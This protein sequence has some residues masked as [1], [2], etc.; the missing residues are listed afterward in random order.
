MAVNLL[1][2]LTDMDSVYSCCSKFNQNIYGC[3]VPYIS[4]NYQAKKN[5]NSTNP[6]HGTKILAASTPSFM[7]RY[8]QEPSHCVIYYLE[9]SLMGRRAPAQRYVTRLM[10]FKPHFTVTTMI[11]PSWILYICHSC[12]L[13]GR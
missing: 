12:G 13:A 9:W 8:V 1:V 10:S 5:R 11:R 6:G 4:T 3:P 7:S 2:S